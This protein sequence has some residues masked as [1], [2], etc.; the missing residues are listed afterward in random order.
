MFRLIRRLFFLALLASIILGVYF[1]NSRVQIIEKFLSKQLNVHVRV[2]TVKIGWNRLLV[3]GLRFENSS[4]SKKIP[5]A[6]QSKTISIET[7]PLELFHE[8]IHIERVRIEN[9]SIGVE[10]FNSFGSNNNWACSLN[11]IA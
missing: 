11:G 2:G 7:T 9:L 5:Y 3:G 1:W 10:L 6:L 8:T 4:S